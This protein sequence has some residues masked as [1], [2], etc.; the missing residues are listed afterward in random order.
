[1]VEVS[2]RLSIDKRQVEVSGM[3]RPAEVMIAIS[4]TAPAANVFFTGMNIYNDGKVISGLQDSEFTAIASEEAIGRI[5][6]H[7]SEDEAWRNL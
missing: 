1:M 2:D 5:W 3:E 7:P 6:N 4:R